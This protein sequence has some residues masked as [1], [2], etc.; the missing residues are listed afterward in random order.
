[1]RHN[2]LEEVDAFN[3]IENDDDRSRAVSMIHEVYEEIRSLVDDAKEHGNNVAL[4]STVTETIE[5]IL[6][7]L[8]HI[9]TIVIDYDEYKEFENEQ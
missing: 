1:M 8:E 3:V 5:T 7:S 9:E 4:I 6:K 2:L